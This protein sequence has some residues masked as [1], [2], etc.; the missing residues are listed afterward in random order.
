MVYLEPTGG[1]INGKDISASAFPHRNAVF[2]LHILP[3][4]DNKEQDTDMINWAKDF[5]EQLTQHATGGVYVNL[6]SHDEEER[7]KNAAYGPNFERLL[8]I[9]TKWDPTNIFSA[10]QNIKGRV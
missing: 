6:M 7:V 2:S 3:G 8:A 4:G 9:K 10:N 5:H 1:A